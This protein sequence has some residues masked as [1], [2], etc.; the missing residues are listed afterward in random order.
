MTRDSGMK[1]AAIA[2]LTLLALP[3]ARAAEW[4]SLG[5]AEGDKFEHFIDLTSVRFAGPIRRAWIK[6][7]YPPQSARGRGDHADTW[8]S[9]R[10]IRSA[11]NCEQETRRI[12][13][14]V[15]S[16]EN[17]TVDSKTPESPPWEPVSPG[18]VDWTHMQFNCS[19]PARKPK[20]KSQPQ[21]KEQTTAPAPVRL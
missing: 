3:S 13:S 15:T 11:Y 14:F 6:L 20:P 16:Y 12:E 21:P 2:T 5:V 1:L 18:S 19:L 7:V 9:E 17:G 8:I 10:M 4:V